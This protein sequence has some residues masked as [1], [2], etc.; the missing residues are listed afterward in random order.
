MRYKTRATP[1][2]C[3]RGRRRPPCESLVAYGEL[4]KLFFSMHDPGKF[5]AQGTSRPKASETGTLPFAPHPRALHHATSQACNLLDTHNPHQYHTPACL[6]FR[7]QGA[8][9]RSLSLRGSCYFGGAGRVRK[10]GGGG[11][12]GADGVGRGGG[13]ACGDGPGAVPQ[14]PRV[15]PTRLSH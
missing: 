9:D 4:L 13:D 1:P 6:V 14:S 15:E 10:S 3:R 2:T 7:V 11:S 12:C 8:W 5:R